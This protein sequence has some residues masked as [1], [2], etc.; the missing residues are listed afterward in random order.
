MHDR[1]FGRLTQL[2]AEVMRFSTGW[3]SGDFPSGIGTLNRPLVAVLVAGRK[4]DRFR[5]ESGRQLRH[6]VDPGGGRHPDPGHDRSRSRRAGHHDQ[7]E[8][9]NAG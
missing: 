7:A 6:L 9:K 2:L 3:I 8:R 1:P 4:P 5:V